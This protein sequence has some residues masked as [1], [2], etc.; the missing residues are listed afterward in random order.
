MSL[1][2]DGPQRQ[3]D[4]VEALDSDAG[5]MARS[6]A[7]LE[8]AGLVERTRSPSDGRAMIVS[9]TESGLALRPQ[10]EAA[11]AELDRVTTG[12]LSPHRVS[13]IV[14]GMAEL[15]RNLAASD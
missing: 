13:Q 3:V 6:I 1:W 7:R 5:T 8:R 15:E 11:W 10:V 14:D 4:L 2:E 12:S 9:I